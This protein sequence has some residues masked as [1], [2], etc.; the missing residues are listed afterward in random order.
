MTLLVS[1]IGIDSRGPSSI[2][3]AS[4]S[5]LS[6][7]NNRSYDH[8]RKVFACSKTADVFG[9]CGDVLFPSMALSQ[10]VD[11][12]DSGLLFNPDDSPEAK[13]KIVRQKLEYQLSSYPSSYPQIT[14]PLI[15]IIHASRSSDGKVFECRMIRW[16]HTGGWSVQKVDLPKRSDILFV[17]G[18]GSKEFNDRYKEYQDGENM[19]TSRNVFHC[20]VDTLARTKTTSVGGAPQ[21]SGIIRKPLS[22]GINYGILAGNKRYAFGAR[23]DELKNFESIAWRNE[24]FEISDGVKKRRVEGAQQQP[25]PLMRLS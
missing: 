3:I 15:E 20:F 7:F 17:R 10:L 8:G 9:Y 23:I 13:S 21:L 5:R 6:F 2:Y 22:C 18:T 1:W 19:G 14:S 4:D 16:S 24:L 12:A 25:N 11:L